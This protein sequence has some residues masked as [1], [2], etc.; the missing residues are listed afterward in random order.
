MKL[1]VSDY[2]ETFSEDLKKNIKYENKFIK[3]GNLFV[4]ATGSSYQSYIDKLGENNFN[5]SYVIVNH[6]TLIIKNGIVIYE[7]ALTCK[8]SKSIYEDIMNSNYSSYFY[9]NKDIRMSDD[10]L[11]KTLKINVVFRNRK[12]AN[13]FKDKILKKYSNLVNCYL[14]YDVLIEIISIKTSKIKAINEIMKLE[15]IEKD[16]VYTIGDGYNDIEMIKEF[17]GYAI[18]N[19]VDELKKVANNVIDSVYELIKEISSK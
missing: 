12:D 10:I 11:D 3:E 14:M 9:C 7:E 1:I 15:N 16:D 17:N 4:I 2:D 13:S 19:S 18:K 6:G 5:A 8:L